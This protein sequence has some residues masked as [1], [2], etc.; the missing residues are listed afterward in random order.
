MIEDINSAGLPPG[1]LRLMD[2]ENPLGPSP[3]AL[4]AIEKYMQAINRYEWF[5][6][7]GNGGLQHLHPV[8]MLIQ[9][10]AKSDGIPLCDPFAPEAPHPYFI[11]S[12]VDQILKLLAVAYLTPGDRELIEAEPGYGEISEK[13]RQIN[14]GGI[15]TRLVRVPLTKDHDH[16]LDA[17]LQAITPKTA[18]V[19]ITNPNNPTGTLLPY[20]ALEQF[21]DAIPEHVVVIIDEA[22]HHFVRDP[23]Y[24]SAMSLA[25]SRDNVVVVRTFAKVYG[26]R[27][28]LL[29]YAITSQ[30]IK[31]KMLVYNHARA[32]PL[33]IM[34][35]IAALDDH[36]HVRRSK[37][38]VIDAKERMY[39]AFNEMGLAYIPSH[40]NFVM[41]HVERDSQA[42]IQSLL[43]LRVAV[44][45]RGSQVLK[46]W[47]R[48]SVGTLPETEVFLTSLKTVLAKI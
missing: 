48:V 42:V 32:S 44:S 43:D 31:K 28:V 21:I 7:D 33:A 11:S 35:G 15:P 6:A 24:R 46:G 13:A 22:Y 23:N 38:V 20:E 34:A 1:L 39:T 10:L 3:L 5:E 30:A 45:P 25:T 2:N 18:L 26:I 14:D 47:I 36:E 37:Q 16:D 12:G 19:T 29:G 4:E 41:V 8:N 40:T 27:G 17:I 9:A